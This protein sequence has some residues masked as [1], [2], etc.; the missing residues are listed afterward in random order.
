MQTQALTSYGENIKRHF[1]PIKSQ[2]EKFVIEITSY[3]Y[4]CMTFIQTFVMYVYALRNKKTQFHVRIA[5]TSQTVA[6]IFKVYNTQFKA[7]MFLFYLCFS[8][9]TLRIYRKCLHELSE[10]TYIAQRL[11]FIFINKFLIPLHQ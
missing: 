8:F 4:H 9:R 3:T 5:Q 6:E 7:Q 10:F 11:M 1:K 2:G